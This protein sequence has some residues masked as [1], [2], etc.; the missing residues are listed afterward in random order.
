MPKATSFDWEWDV[1]V[2]AVGEENAAKVVSA[3]SGH[4]VYF[5]TSFGR[6][7]RREQAAAEVLRLQAEG[8]SVKQIV[9]RIHGGESHVR[10]LLKDAKKGKV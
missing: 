9:H 4:R 8:L 1:L 2:G 7:A 3:F 10:Q 6:R 5:P